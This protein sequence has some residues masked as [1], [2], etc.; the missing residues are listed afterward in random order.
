MSLSPTDY[1][2]FEDARKLEKTSKETARAFVIQAV[3]EVAQVVNAIDHGGGS[4]GGGIVH[5]ATQTQIDVD[6]PVLCRTA[7]AIIVEALNSDVESKLISLE[8]IGLEKRNLAFQHVAE[9][10]SNLV[11]EVVSGVP[12]LVGRNEDLEGLFNLNKILAPLL[13]AP[14]EPIPPI[15]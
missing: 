2:A 4:H 11:I 5:V 12:V 6:P 9:F 14:P 13:P 7:L 3:Q 8:E 15:E 1:K 10:F